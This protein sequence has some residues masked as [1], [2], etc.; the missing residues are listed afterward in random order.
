MRV[1]GL[2]LR[3]DRQTRRSAARLAVGD[4]HDLQAGDPLEERTR[5]ISEVEHAEG[6]TR[7]V[8]RDA[9]DAGVRAGRRQVLLGQEGQDVAGP[10]AF[11]CS[12]A[13]AYIAGAVLA[14][15]GGQRL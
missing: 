2:G 8:V 9:L 11:L 1:G 3:D 6:V 15:D 5:L 4:V 12:P 13:A 10:V 14:V 7:V